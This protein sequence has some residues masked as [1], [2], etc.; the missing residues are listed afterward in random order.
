MECVHATFQS[1]LVTVVCED[2]CDR[3]ALLGQLSTRGYG[4]VIR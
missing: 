4:G 3:E 2:G 1:H